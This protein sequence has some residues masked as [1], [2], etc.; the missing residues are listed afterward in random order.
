MTGQT[1]GADFPTTSGSAQ[2]ALPQ[3]LARASPAASLFANTGTAFVTKFT[4]DGSRPYIRPFWQ[5][6]RKHSTRMLIDPAG[7]AIVTGNTTS[8]D[9]PITRPARLPAYVSR[10]AR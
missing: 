7:E 10:S 4:A 1:S 8:P 9:F 2:P 6:L 3:P 5:G